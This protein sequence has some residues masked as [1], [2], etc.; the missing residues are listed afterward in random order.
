VEMPVMD[1]LE[2]TAAIRAREQSAGGRVPII[3]MTAHAIKG[4]RQQ[5]LDAGMDDYITKPIRPEEMFNALERI[6]ADPPASRTN[7]VLLEV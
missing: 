7:S 5:C 1:G 4:V 2:A 6:T 3:A